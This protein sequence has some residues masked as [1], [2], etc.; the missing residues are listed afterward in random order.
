M[1]EHRKL[2]RHKSMR[3]KIVDVVSKISLVDGK[4]K[5][6]DM[7]LNGYQRW[8]EV[9]EYGLPF[10]SSKGGLKTKKT[11]PSTDVTEQ[12]SPINSDPSASAPSDSTPG[13]PMGQERDKF[14]MWLHKCTLTEDLLGDWIERSWG[15][16]YELEKKHAA[17]R[18][19]TQI[20]EQKRKKGTSQGGQ[21]GLLV[22]LWMLPWVCAWALGRLGVGSLAVVGRR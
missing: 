17:E 9:D 3:E 8:V 21:G 15:Y 2:S 16:V 22:H 1:G 20:A 14:M 18:R 7:I 13:G 11:N 19:A 6:S 12:L 4:A 10:L 5:E